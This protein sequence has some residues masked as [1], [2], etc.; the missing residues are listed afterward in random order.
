M[1]KSSFD[2]LFASYSYSSYWQVDEFLSNIKLWSSYSPKL[3]VYFVKYKD[4][5]LDGTLADTGNIFCFNVT[6]VKSS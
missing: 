6:N 3:V 5:G 4:S 1:L 2:H